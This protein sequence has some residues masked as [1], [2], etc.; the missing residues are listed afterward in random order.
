M[1]SFDDRE[2][3]EEKKFQLSQELEFKSQAR[4]NKLLGLWAAEL[5]GLSGAEAEQYAKT[6]VAA[7]MAEAGDE[8]VFRKVRGDFDAKGVTQSDHQ[9][10]SR[11]TDLLAEARAQVKAGG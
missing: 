2:R 3:G 6:V 8:D 9:I 1:S 11:M 4:R 5:M 10:R 7:D